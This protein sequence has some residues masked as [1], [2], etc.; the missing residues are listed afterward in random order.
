MSDTKFVTNNLSTLV[1][2]RVTTSTRNAN[3]TNLRES[4]GKCSRT[5]RCPRC[6]ADVIKMSTYRGRTRHVVCSVSSY[7]LVAYGVCMGFYG[8]FP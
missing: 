1:E 5:S 4:R 2:T 7:I 6:I 3:E 8:L